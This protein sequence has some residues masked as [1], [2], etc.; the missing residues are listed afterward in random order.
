V[1]V[2]LLWIVVWG[3]VSGGMLPFVLERAGFD[4]A[5]ASGPLVT[6]LVDVTGLL[7]Y[8]SIASVVLAGTLL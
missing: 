5:S 8:F 4:P 6:T 1:A 3:A 2:S 7:I